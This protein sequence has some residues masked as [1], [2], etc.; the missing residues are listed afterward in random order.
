MSQRLSRKEIKQKDSFMEQMGEAIEYVSS[1]ARTLMWIGVGILVGVVLIA[2]FVSYRQGI[3]READVAL[4]EAIRI[5]QAPIVAEGADQDGNDPTFSDEANRRKRAKMALESVSQD[6]SGSPA[7]EIALAYLGQIAA[8]EGDLDTARATWESFL[9]RQSDHFLADEVQVNLMALDRMQ[10]RGDKLVTQ[11]RARLS[12]G[13]SSLPPD[14]V[15]FELAV[16]LDSL[17]RP[18]EATLAYQRIVE[19]H[20]SSAFAAEARAHSG[21]Q[22]TSFL[23]GT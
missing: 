4:S 14:V 12:S 9:K 18:E 11:L 22:Q 2:I 3:Q 15:L 16:T 19:E 6:Y 7:A 20:P 5:Q 21:I 8:D 13:D 1:H 23:G 10:G 17:G